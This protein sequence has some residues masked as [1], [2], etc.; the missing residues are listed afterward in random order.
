MEYTLGDFLG[1]TFTPPL[2]FLA[3]PVQHTKHPQLLK[4]WSHLHGYLSGSRSFP[5]LFSAR[6]RALLLSPSVPLL[7]AALA[8][9]EQKPLE[10]GSEVVGDITHIFPQRLSY[11]SELPS[12]TKGF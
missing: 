3:Q 10:P 5:F 2:P 8:P 9:C 6:G 11:T 1:G 7:L 4:P 12:A